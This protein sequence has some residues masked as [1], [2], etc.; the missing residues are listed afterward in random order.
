LERGASKDSSILV[1]KFRYQLSSRAL[2]GRTAEAQ[3]LE[4]MVGSKRFISMSAT[5]YCEVLLTIHRKGY[6]CRSGTFIHYRIQ[7]IPHNT[8][9]YRV[10]TEETFPM[11]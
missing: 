4:L 1:V 10:D 2:H 6:N 9:K 7:I 5:L 8:E 3:F 11:C